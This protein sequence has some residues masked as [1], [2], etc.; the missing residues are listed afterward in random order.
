MCV[1]NSIKERSSISPFCLFVFIIYLYDM[2]KRVYTN[3]KNKYNN[4]FIHVLVDNNGDIYPFPSKSMI[5]LFIQ[6]NE[7]LDFKYQKFDSTLEFERFKILKSFEKEGV[8]T[9]LETQVSFEL[10]PSQPYDEK[11]V[12]PNGVVSYK[13]RTMRGTKYIADFTYKHD[14]VLVV[15]DTKSDITKKKPEYRIKKKLMLMIHNILI[16]E[17]T[18]RW[19]KR[20]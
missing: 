20:L 13:R 7:H 9:D 4:R 14:G 18:K 3:K 11:T 6:Q 10:I 8:I 1:L 17:V 16:K 19:I 5:P 2:F 15:E 12:Q